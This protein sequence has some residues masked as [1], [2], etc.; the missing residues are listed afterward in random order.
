[1]LEV[2][3]PEGVDRDGADNVRTETCRAFTREEFE[4]I[5]KAI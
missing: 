3:R 5:L 1:L 4:K 2:N